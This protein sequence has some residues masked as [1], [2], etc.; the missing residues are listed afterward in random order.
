LLR[1][2]STYAT[3]LAQ[4]LLSDVCSNVWKTPLVGFICDGVFVKSV[5]EAWAEPFFA[6]DPQAFLSTAKPFPDHYTYDINE[7][8]KDLP[9]HW[10]DSLKHF[11]VKCK[12][13]WLP[14]GRRPTADCIA[15]LSTSPLTSDLTPKLSPYLLRG[16]TAKKIHEVQTS[17]TSH[18]RHLTILNFRSKLYCLLLPH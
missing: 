6:T 15:S 8:T 16:M 10:P 14:R 2:A 9:H 4:F 5:P 17:Q 18:L 1:S 13:L 11:V 12:T 7:L 3:D